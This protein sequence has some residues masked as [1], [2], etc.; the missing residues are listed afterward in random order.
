[1][2]MEMGDIE[3][4]MDGNPIMM[5][6]MGQAMADYDQEYDDEEEDPNAGEDALQYEDFRNIIETEGPQNT[7]MT[8]LRK[9]NFI[10]KGTAIWH[11]QQAIQTGEQAIS[12]FAKHGVNIP[13][14][15]L[16][17]NRKPVPATQYRP[18]DLVVQDDDKK[19]KAEYFTISAQGVVQVFNSAKKSRVLT[20]PAEFFTL[21]DWMQQT[22]LFNVLTS[23]KFFKL[24]LISKVFSLWKG[25]VRHHTF[26]KTRLELAKNLIQARPDFQTTYID[27]NRMLYDMLIKPTF[28]LNK[29][30]TSVEIS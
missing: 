9:A 17:C 28:Y 11:M 3:Y 21:S 18:Y 12:F 24:Y 20:Q 7:Q 25:N 19:L 10:R 6:A 1:M 8:D 14:K 26:H 2:N 29:N 13:I 15:F 27:I 5:D 23:M 22:T 4:D 30:G 16:N